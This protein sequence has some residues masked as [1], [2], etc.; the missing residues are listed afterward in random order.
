VKTA[1]SPQLEALRDRREDACRLRAERALATFDDAVAFL[2]DRGM[3]TRTPDSALPSLFEACHEPPYR[4]G[5]QGFAAWP[6]TKWWWA[7]ALGRRPGV[8]TLKIHRGKSLLMTKE[9]LALVDPIC[10]AELERFT[11]SRAAS[12]QD[13]MERRLLDHLSDVG[14]SP[15]ESVQL[16]LGLHSRALRALRSPLE[17]CGALVSREV[18]S[19]EVVSHEGVSREG[20]TGADGRR[21]ELRIEDR[22]EGDDAPN[23]ADSGDGTAAVLAHSHSSEVMRYDQLVPEPLG[24]ARDARDALEDLLV[25]GVRAA[26]LAPERELSKWFSWR[27]YLRADAVD[28]L[29]ESGRIVRPAPGYVAVGPGTGVAAAAGAVT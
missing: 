15:L 28:R 20:V 21:I 24:G 8:S 14:P 3:L 16:E 9:T 22:A 1:V 17:R 26:V 19:S 6:A 5:G 12:E 2:E 18:V 29:V 7:G 4:Q 23:A 10:R 25:A 11:A 13:R 27:W